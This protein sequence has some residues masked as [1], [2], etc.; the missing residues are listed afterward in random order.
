MHRV[1]EAALGGKDHVEA[2]IGELKGPKRTPVCEPH[3][4]NDLLRAHIRA[5]P[6]DR[7]SLIVALKVLRKAYVNVDDLLKNRLSP[8]GIADDEIQAIIQDA[9][10]D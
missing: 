4:I 6:P 8:A 10:T 5:P 7:K 9:L 3:V 1:I 2:F